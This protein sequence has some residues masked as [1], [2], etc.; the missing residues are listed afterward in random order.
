MIKIGIDGKPGAGKT[1]LSNMLL[2]GE[3]GVRIIHMDHILD[4]LKN[5]L[6]GSMVETYS[7]NNGVKVK[8]LNKDTIFYK[9]IKAR[10]INDF[11]EKVRASY[12][13][14][15]LQKQI[16]LAEADNIKYLIIESFSLDRYIDFDELD[17]KILIMATS[18]IRRKRVVR[19]DFDNK[20]GIRE[21]YFTSQDRDSIYSDTYD[22]VVEN[23]EDLAHLER[24]AKEIESVVKKYQVYK[25]ERKF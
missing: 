11:Y 13:R 6:C 24:Q 4:K 7:E 5:L 8:C 22:F 10:L 15:L 14:N 23:T 9:L 21:E 17:F 1:T 25:R 3:D 18:E 12:I 16:A 20:Y 19:R 2:D